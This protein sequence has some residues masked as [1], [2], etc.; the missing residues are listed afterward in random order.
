MPRPRLSTCESF[1]RSS[2]DGDRARH[3]RQRRTQTSS[4]DG[5]MTSRL[6]SCLLLGAVVA[7]APGTISAGSYKWVD[8]KGNVTYSDRPP[9]SADSSAPAEV[10]PLSLKNLEVVKPAMPV[11]EQDYKK[12]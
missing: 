7:L 12:Y 1:S 10:V 6:K 9:Q 3:C 5:T 4:L 11:Q 8:E 2:I